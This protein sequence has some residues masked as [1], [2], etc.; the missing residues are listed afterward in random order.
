MEEEKQESM[1]GNLLLQ[2]MTMASVAP[3]NETNEMK[4]MHNKF[5]QQ[6]NMLK[7]KTEAIV[8][9]IEMPDDLTIIQN[10]M[11][12]LDTLRLDDK[13][14]DDKVLDE[15]K[16]DANECCKVLNDKVL[17][18]LDVLKEIELKYNLHK[19]STQNLKKLKDKLKMYSNIK[20]KIDIN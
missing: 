17:D 12:E 1:Y 10:I 3:T 11:K 13:I 9:S 7:A 19:C 5:K 8:V 6:L 14:L 4:Q 15:I 2:H 16:K 18:V 20:S